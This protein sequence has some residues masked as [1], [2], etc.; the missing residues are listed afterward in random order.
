ML[1]LSQNI[2]ELPYTLLYSSLYMTIIYWMVGLSGDLTNFCM[3]LLIMF[4]A[5][6]TAVSYGM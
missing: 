2:S 1:F 4:V 6:S 5:D 3:A